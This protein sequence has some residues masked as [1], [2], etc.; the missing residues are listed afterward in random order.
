MTIIYIL[1]SKIKSLKKD[2]EIV[3]FLKKP[4][5]RLISYKNSYLN[6]R[7]T[8]VDNIKKKYFLGFL[9]CFTI[10]GCRCQENKVSTPKKNAESTFEVKQKNDLGSRTPTEIVSINTGPNFRGAS[11][12]ATL[13]VVHIKSTF[14]IS[15][16]SDILGPL[17][18][19]F[20]FR[21]FYDGG[22]TKLR[23]EASGVIVSSDGYIVTSEHVVSEAEDIEIILHNKKSYKA[24]II[25]I[26]KETDLALLKIDE[27]KL[28]FIEFGN[29]D[30]V[31]VGD[32]VLAVG[33]P[34]E[35]T[36]TVTAGIVSAKARNI[37]LQ[38]RKG[39]IDSYLQTD[40]AINPGNSGGALVDYNG[41][42]IGINTA[43]ATL[44]GRY[45]GYSF[46]TPINVVKKIIDD[47]LIKGKVMRAYL[48]AAIKDM[49]S[50][51]SKHLNTDF[52]PGV[53][54]D[55]LYK[56]GAALEAD[57]KVNDIIINKDDRK[58]ESA[59]QFQEL[60]EQHRPG[61]KIV[62]TIIRKGNEKSIPV[63]LKE[64][65]GTTP[66]VNPYKT[67]LL[68][69]LGIKIDI[70]NE[71]EKKQLKIPGGIKVVEVSKGIILKYTNI[72][73]G[74]IIK[75]INGKT[76]KTEDEFIKACID[77]EH[78]IVLEGVYP[79]SSNIF[80]YAFGLD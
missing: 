5:V 33:N 2:G 37:N 6:L 77:S 38:K 71:K 74:F 17:Y 9:F 45:A 64:I 79:N 16:P 52:I 76:I 31:E 13:G 36:S 39:A 22:K 43:I 67:V 63:V 3:V 56:G 34:F 18:E 42:L 12:I 69:A 50:E 4:L 15:G 80:Y 68:N 28:S 1:Q 19:D 44:T 41:K 40:A 21:F 14:S 58:I 23:S 53:F 60:L 32:W 78:V 46:S 49:T 62:L 59:S 25:G 27:T 57:L 72:K 7:Y 75:K 10:L 24:K 29:S 47:L 55:S 54:I 70:L 73:S 65:E 26:D 48:G 51:N 30:N 35:L 11:K 61:E 8:L 66:E 20:W